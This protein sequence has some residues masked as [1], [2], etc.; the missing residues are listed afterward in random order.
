M[1]KSKHLGFEGRAD[2]RHVDHYRE[3]GS[4]RKRKTAPR[5]H[6]IIPE[7]NV[8]LTLKSCLL[9]GGL[10]IKATLPHLEV[11]ERIP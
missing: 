5:R 3:Q 1:Q 9:F 4:G 8:T 7:V 6:V 10:D 11:P 2:S